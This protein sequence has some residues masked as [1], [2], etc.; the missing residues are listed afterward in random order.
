MS[1]LFGTDGV[2]GLANGLLTAELAL[3]L[4]QAA[5]VVLGHDR[6]S[7]GSR[8]RAV[9]ARDPRASGEFI[10]AAVEAGLSS[11]GIDVYD[12]GV[13]PTPAA[14]YLVADLEADFGVM[15]SASHNPAPDNGIKF[16]ARGGQKLPDDVEDA[17]EAQMHNEAVRPIGPDVG[18]IQR[19]SDAEDRYVVHLLSTL[20]HRLEGLTV[21]LDCAHGAASG[22]SPQ[23]FK[24]AGADVIVI[25][26]DPDGLNIND[27]VGSTHLGP[28]KEAVLQYGAD[29]GIA[30]D[31][32]ADRCLA[33]DHEGNEVDGDQ[34][35]AVLAVALKEAGKLNDDV[36]VATVMSNLGLKI[37]LRDAG[38]SIRETAVGDR[39]VLE[40]MR[41]G[42]F[43]LGGEQ[44]G[45]VIFSDHAT[46]G[47]GLL[48]GLQ[49]AAQVALTGKSLKDLAAVM[50]K[51]PQV[52]INVKGVDRTKVKS[53]D[54]LAQAVKAAEAA[55]GE[56]GRVLL[57]PSGT[58]PV[59]RVMVEAADEETAQSIAE[60]LAQ[61]VRTELALEL[62]SE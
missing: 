4:A 39:Y 29:L 55:L 18:R 24:D 5:A 40:S 32:D 36:L 9:V 53:S 41:E 47:D 6:N 2:R 49:L 1:R 51:L 28:L 23:V 46:T 50:T 3:Q 34:I 48:T 45:H 33:V 22:C 14:A 21:V 7:N 11:S 62:I 12:A 42:G 59:V 61:V 27:G 38:I 44:S 43:N 16:F 37:A 8:P 15:I 58:E 17:I 20:P 54:V 25:G 56:T 57:R 19:F 13:L 60:H 35:M 26:A 31:G 30:H 52:L 10:A